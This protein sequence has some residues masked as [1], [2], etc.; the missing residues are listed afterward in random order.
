METGI[1]TKK[2]TAK[3]K[4]AKELPDMSIGSAVGLDINELKGEEACFARK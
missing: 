4:T 1:V 3:P 2:L